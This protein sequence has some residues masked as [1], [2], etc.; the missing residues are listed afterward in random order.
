[1][2]GLPFFPFP[3]PSFS[4]TSL[5]LSCCMPWG[6]V[7]W[8]ACVRRPISLVRH[9]ECNDILHIFGCSSSSPTTSFYYS[10]CHVL[11][12]FRLNVLSS[13]F[14]S[15]FCSTLG[16]IPVSPLLF[17]LS[18]LNQEFFLEESI[19]LFFFQ[20]KKEPLTTTTATKKQ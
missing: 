4:S 15:G 11:V 10:S 6:R 19:Y 5:R 13:I 14:F 20:T 2:P 18:I 16:N 1:M 17:R 12:L 8:R 3:P 9:L 7:C